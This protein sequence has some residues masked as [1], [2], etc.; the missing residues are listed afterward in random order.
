[1]PA[2]RQYVWAFALIA[3]AASVAGLFLTVWRP[4]YRPSTQKLPAAPLPYSHVQFTAK[5]AMRAFAALG[6]KLIPKSRV[7]DVVTTIGSANAAF[8]VDVF[9]D[10]S[11]VNALGGS[12]EIIVDSHGNYVRIPSTCNS[13]IPDAE[14]W[15]GNVRVVIRC[16]NP[17]HAQLLN[18]GARALANL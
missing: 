4:R 8:E 6:V 15:R 3:L 13:G 14:R 10:S 2:I 9:G 16:A 18:T 11:Q 5:D 7:P 12:P 1:V 17:A